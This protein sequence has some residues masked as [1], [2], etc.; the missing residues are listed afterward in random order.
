MAAGD[1]KSGL[2]SVASGGFLNIQPPLGEEW[3]ITNIYVPSG[4]SAE[5]Y[6]SDGVNS[7]LIDTRTASWVGYSFH[8]T[9]SLYLRVKNADAA[10]QYIGYSGIQ[11]K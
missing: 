2:A 9:N 10:A 8:V 4:K 3:V 1:V 7:V 6:L 11:T 5:L